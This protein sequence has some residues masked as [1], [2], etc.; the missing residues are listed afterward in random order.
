MGLMARIKTT[1]ANHRLR[2]RRRRGTAAFAGSS[3]VVRIPVK[4][5]VALL[6]GFGMW[7]ASA[8]ANTPLAA[9][10]QQPSAQTLPA[11]AAAENASA[12][13]DRYCVGC[14]SNTL[15]TAGLS[16]QAMD[17]ANPA[18][19]GDVWERVVRKLRA[20]QMPPASARRPDPAALDSL[21]A[22]LEES[23][24]RTA[25]GRPNPGR[26]LL[27]R[28]NRAEYANVIRDLVDLEVDV[29]PLLPAD[30]ST[31]GFDNIAEVLGVSPLLQERYLAAAER[32][33]AL[34]VGDPR[35]SAGSTTYRVR[36]DLSQNQ[37]IEGLPIGTIGGVLGRP[38]LPLDGDYDIQVR[39]MRTNTGAMRG[40][41]YP[42]QLEILVDGER[43]HL[44][45]FG[46]D[47]DLRALY[48]NPTLA[49][50]A[51][52]AR[53]KVRVHL[54][55]GPHEIGTAFVEKTNAAPV[56][57]LQPFLRSS[58][59]MDTSGFPHMDLLSITG[60][61]NSSGPGDTPSRRR[62]FTCRPATAAQETGC[63]TKIL[64]TIARRAYRR[65]V[66][67]AETQDLL[68]YFDS[69]RASGG[70]FDAGIQMA[71]RRVL[72]SPKFVFR[73]EADP[74]GVAPGT[75][76]RISDLE[77]ASRLSFFLWSSMPDDELLDVASRGMLKDPDT[78][79]GQ[80]RRMLAHP[81]STALVTN[82]AGQW[83]YLRNLR[84]MVPDS[85]VFPDFDDNL[86]QALQRE[87]ELFVESIMREDRNVFDLLTAD[88]TFVNERL[89]R[90]YGI[91]NIYGS[92]FRRVTIRD[93]ARRGL[94]GK[95]AIL[96]VTSQANRTSPVIR[97]KW[98]LQNLVGI[99]PAPPPPNVPMLKEPGEQDRPLT[100]RERMAAHRNNPVC[101]SCHNVMDPLGFALEHFDA[102]GAWR[103]KDAGAPVD[104]T[105]QFWDGTS[106]DGA[107]GLRQALL[108]RPEVFVQTMT[109]KLLTYAL[110]RG[111]DYHDMPVVR[112]I[113]RQS[114][115]SGYR[116]SS[117]V[118]GIVNSMPFQMRMKAAPD[119]GPGSTRTE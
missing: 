102:V 53:L 101:G 7:L 116:F 111:L 81:R 47:T 20:G 16:L 6:V 100:M 31:Y 64:T 98:I 50:D 95:G 37:H 17:P 41:E 91:P 10:P 88:Y 94:L 12:V 65:P 84:G 90:H 23:L 3:N 26:P 33:S 18:A 112:A 55:A 56:E 93:E 104:A 29:T 75:A 83:L 61:F 24:D 87:T 38:T 59:T 85:N 2:D 36:Q 8:V 99:P 76:Y 60:P 118:L 15:K 35:L 67:S 43:V 21:I 13:V 82:F 77:L 45:S 57:R 103:D 58:D 119:S 106:I 114:S 42:H 78:L 80:T 74:A 51:V 40:L 117:L 25:T 54:N 22:W 89:A 28:L 68:R 32:I 49:S 27:H 44:A 19:H 14:H 70:R 108:K 9:G 30:D 48:Q 11:G 109:E 34:A 79:A 4:S 86:R 105:G 62:I 97:G 92:H 46:G 73:S 5:R 107:V 96:A 52:D 110:G 72:A 71:L 113:L 63:A 1:K 39:F 66:T 115:A 69:G